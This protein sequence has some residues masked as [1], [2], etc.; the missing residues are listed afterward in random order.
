MEKRIKEREEEEEWV[1][2]EA[3]K[4]RE[5]KVKEYEEKFTKQSKVNW[6]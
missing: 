1:R 3:K 4:K 5:Q 2:D 6:Q